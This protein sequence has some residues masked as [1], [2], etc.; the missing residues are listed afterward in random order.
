MAVEAAVDFTC[1]AVE[2]RL[3]RFARVDTAQADAAASRAM[4]PAQALTERGEHRIMRD[5]AEVL[6]RDG[7]GLSLAARRAGENRLG[8][9]WGPDRTP[10]TP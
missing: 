3:H 7:L 10:A 4:M 2:R 8:R 6:D 9:N 5:E 1:I